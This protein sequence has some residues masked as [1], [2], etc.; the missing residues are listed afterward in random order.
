LAQA[1]ADKLFEIG[2]AVRKAKKEKQTKHEEEYAAAKA[3]APDGGA[4]LQ[5]PETDFDILD[6]LINMPDY[7]L[8]QK[9]HLTFSAY[10]CSINCF[11]EVFQVQENLD[12]TMPIDLK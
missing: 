12:G 6:C 3:A 10:G 11:F 2:F 1:A 7:P 5:K 4:S 8:T 9:E